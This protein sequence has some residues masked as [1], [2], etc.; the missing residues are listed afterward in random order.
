VVCLHSDR[1]VSGLVSEPLLVSLLDYLPMPHWSTVVIQ[2]NILTYRCGG[3]IGIVGSFTN[4]RTNAPISRFTLRFKNSIKENLLPK[5]V[6]NL[7][8]GVIEV[9]EL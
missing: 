4:K 6:V 5:Q 9:N 2:P 7:T 1:P 3:S 8:I